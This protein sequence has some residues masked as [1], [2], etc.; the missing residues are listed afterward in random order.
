MTGLL[1]VQLHVL[2]CRNLHRHL[3][4]IFLVLQGTALVR[5]ALI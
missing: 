1:K 4:R 3:G 2:A 5:T